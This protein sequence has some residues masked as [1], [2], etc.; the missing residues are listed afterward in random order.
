MNKVPEFQ[1]PI[2]N[3]IVEISREFAKDI[4]DVDSIIHLF[5]ILRA[6]FPNN[7]M[8]LCN[9]S[10]SPLRS[11]TNYVEQLKVASAWF[12][13]PDVEVIGK[14]R[15]SVE[16][17]SIDGIKKSMDIASVVFNKVLFDTKTVD[18][19]EEYFG[20]ENLVDISEHIVKTFSEIVWLNY[21][22]RYKLRNIQ[23]ANSVLT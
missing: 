14:R 3:P 10:V 4:E 19:L 5:L 16:L 11:I 9:G 12:N 23:E 7:I 21:H 13:R 2:G 18:R 6:F 1:M 17:N 15:H 22:S 8:V 20:R